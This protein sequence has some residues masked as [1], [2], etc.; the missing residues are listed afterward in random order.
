VD[1]W[2]A[3]ASTVAAVRAL[4]VGLPVHLHYLALSLEDPDAFLAALKA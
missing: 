1:R 3:S 4:A 2:A